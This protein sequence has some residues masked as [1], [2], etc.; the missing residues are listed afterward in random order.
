MMPPIAYGRD[1]LSNQYIFMYIRLLLAVQAYFEIVLFEYDFYPG[2]TFD[3]LL[4]LIVLSII[5][6]HVVQSVRLQARYFEHIELY[7]SSS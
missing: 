3:G 4:K 2:S 6:V 7:T 1:R 5:W